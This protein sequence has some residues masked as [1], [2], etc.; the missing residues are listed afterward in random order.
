MAQESDGHILQMR[1]TF[2]VYKL[3][4]I[5]KERFGYHSEIL[6]YTKE[7]SLSFIDEKM[8]SVNLNLFFGSFAE[9]EEDE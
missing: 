7:Q 5:L 2:W 9:I 1:E 8:H 3:A 6:N 4:T